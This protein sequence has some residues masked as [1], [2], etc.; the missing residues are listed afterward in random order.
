MRSGV[1]LLVVLTAD[2]ARR[3]EPDSAFLK[4]LKQN[5]REAVIWEEIYP[6]YVAVEKRNAVERVWEEP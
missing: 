3:A 4:R 6:K 2:L 1:F 5:R